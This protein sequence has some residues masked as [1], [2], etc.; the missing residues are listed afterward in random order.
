MKSLE[1]HLQTFGYE[2]VLPNLPLTYL[3]FD[4][5]AK[6]LEEML[7]EYFQLDLKNDEKIHFVG[8]STG[9]LVIRKL[10]NE[11]KHINK[12]GRCVLIAT[13][14][15]GSRLATI[16]SRMK[17]YVHI[18]KTLKSL[19]YEYLQQQQLESSQQIEI[20]AIAGTRN[21]LLLGRLISEQNDGR[22]EVN[23]VQFLGLK[24]FIT[25]PYGHK[26]IHHQIETATYVDSFLKTGKF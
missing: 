8:H 3:E 22:I 26:D 23:S 5:A 21:N 9:G 15:K 25:L 6:V 7:D 12:I 19:S 18:Y 13:P 1:Q 10:L 16:A 4:L 11:T 24:D 17:P 20:A 14:N 2:C